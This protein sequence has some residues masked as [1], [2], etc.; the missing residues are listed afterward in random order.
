MGKSVNHRKPRTHCSLEISLTLVLRKRNGEKE[1]RGPGRVNASTQVQGVSL[2][3]VPV[4]RV[5][6]KRV[7]MSPEDP[8]LG[9][10]S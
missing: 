6:R 10:R 9:S 2:R 7:S 1:G 8:S 3:V 4:E 5:S